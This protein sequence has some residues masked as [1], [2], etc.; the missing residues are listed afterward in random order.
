V[1]VFGPDLSSYQHGLNLARLSQASFVIAKT[2]EGTYYT[3]ADYDGWR[4][5]AASLGRL[6]CWYHFLSGEDAKAQAA[7]TRQHVGD[8]SL[9]GMLDIEPTNSFTPTLRQALDY[10]DAARAAGLNLRLAYLPRWF[11]EQLG[12]PDLSALTARGLHLIS[13]SYPG[14]SGTPNRLYPGDGASG[15][16]SYGGITP[17]LYQF[18]NQASDGGMALDYNAFRGTVAQLAS[19]LDQT[20]GGPAMSNIP[21]TISQK[22]PDIAGEFPPNAP[23][24]DEVAL[25]WSDAG[26]RAAALY[27]REA[28]DAINAL[29]SR[30]S[31]PPAI[32]VAALAAALAPHLAAG[33]TPDQLAEAVVEHLGTTLSKG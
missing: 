3:D 5:Q 14:G 4:R 32:D 22:W 9:P 12:S 10:A 6:F 18:T 31:Q 2:T 30:I 8:L 16:S 21:P 26:S 1:T 11:W 28:R 24:T 19:A 13:S 15:W 25:I 17:L 33:A 7:H 23:Y 27:A 20:S 29:A